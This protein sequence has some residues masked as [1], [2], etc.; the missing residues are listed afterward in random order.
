MHIANRISN[1]G[2]R[3]TKR[4]QQQ[5]KYIMKGLVNDFQ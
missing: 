1:Q 3:G 5:E 4:N 2:E